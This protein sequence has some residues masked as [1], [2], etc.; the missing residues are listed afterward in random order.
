MNLPCFTAEASVYKSHGRYVMGV[1]PGDTISPRIIPTVMPEYIKVA[2]MVGLWGFGG[3]G[4]GDSNCYLR[5]GIRYD[6]E[7]EILSCVRN[8]DIF[9]VPIA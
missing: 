5:C 9:G 3:D 7:Y 6:R 4:D 2:P 1:I 8:C